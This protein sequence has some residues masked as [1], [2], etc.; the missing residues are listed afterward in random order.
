MSTVIYTGLVC[1]HRGHYD[2]LIE[3]CKD[4]KRLFCATIPCKQIICGRL[5][6]LKWARANVGLQ[7]LSPYF[8]RA[9]ISPSSAV[10]GFWKTKKDVELHFCLRGRVGVTRT[11]PISRR[12]LK[13]P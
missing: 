2:L 3:T 5:H 10:L 8:I 7:T 12:V 4:A 6:F 1:V 13:Y 11:L 9:V